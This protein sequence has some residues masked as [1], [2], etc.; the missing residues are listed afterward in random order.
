MEKPKTRPTNTLADNGIFYFSKEV[1]S[2]SCAEAIKFILETNLKQLDGLESIRL[3]INSPGGDLQAALALCDIMDGSPIPVETYGIGTIYSA[4][5]LI[6]MAG[7]KKSRTITPNT[8]IMSHQ[9][10]WG[11]SGKEHELF[12]AAKGFDLIKSRFMNHYK[13][14]TGLSEKKISKY[15]LPPHDVWIDTEEA[16][17]LGIADDIRIFEV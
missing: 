4:G 2:E 3:I 5:L 15:L 12:A 17:Q 16:V 6:F 14:Y 10:Q 8:M 9:W 1:T 13:K 7:K 11:A